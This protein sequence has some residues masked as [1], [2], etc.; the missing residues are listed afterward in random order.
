LTAAKK[1]LRAIN[2]L[3]ARLAAD[4]PAIGITISMPSVHT[5]QVLAACG[6]DWLFLD[7]EHGPI[8]IEA[9]HAMMPPPAAAGPHRWSACRGTCTGWSSRCWMPAPWASSSR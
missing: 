5:T 2:P 4:K 8:G 6:F 9:V 7:M 3:K 1:Q